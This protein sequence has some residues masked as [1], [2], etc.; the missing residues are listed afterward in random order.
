MSVRVARL[1]MLISSPASCRKCMRGYE[2]V[3]V[4]WDT[5]PPIRVAIIHAPRMRSA[6][7]ITY[8]KFILASPS[9]CGFPCA[10]MNLNPENTI[11]SARTGSATMTM[12]RRAPAM[13]PETVLYSDLSGFVNPPVS[14]AYTGRA[15][16][17]ITNTK[18]VVNFTSDVEREKYESE[19]SY[20]R[21][22]ELETNKH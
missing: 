5:V 17:S 7:K 15:E 18:A 16:I 6:P 12:A 22:E 11:K 9:F 4:S 19:L 21:A 2:L 8:T 10:A 1:R 13:K 14:A 3:P 20:S